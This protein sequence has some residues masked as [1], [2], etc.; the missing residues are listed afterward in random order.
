MPPVHRRYSSNMQQTM[1][2]RYSPD[3]DI[4][5]RSLKATGEPNGSSPRRQEMTA[6]SITEFTGIFVLSETL[7]QIRQP[8]TPRSREK[9][10]EFGI[11]KK[12]H[13]G[14][15]D[16]LQNCR[17]VVAKT[18]VTAQVPIMTMIVDIMQVPVIELVAW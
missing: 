18:P 17:E 1:Y 6:V 14:T 16:Y 8:G 7:L 2:D 9:A 15:V 4:D 12:F 13:H 10:P 3:V 11:R 5:V